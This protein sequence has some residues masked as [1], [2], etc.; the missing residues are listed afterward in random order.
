MAS[1]DAT[2]ESL[3]QFVK[4]EARSASDGQL[5]G[6]GIIGVLVVAGALHW[7]P[8]AWPVFTAMG[9][10]LLALAAWGA[11]DR[12]LYERSLAGQSSHRLLRA[13]RAAAAYIGWMAMLVAIF[14]L[15]GVAL[16]T[17]IS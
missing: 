14:G 12:E 10:M 3:G 17:I 11:I 13:A 16:G 7:R 5:A 1:H 9:A 8:P 4:R 15:L 2:N 6:A